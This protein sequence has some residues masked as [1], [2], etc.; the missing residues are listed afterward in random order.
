MVKINLSFL[1]KTHTTTSCLTIQLLRA[2]HPVLSSSKYI[3]SIIFFFLEKTIF[4]F[5]NISFQLYDNSVVQL[6]FLAELL[7]GNIFLKTFIRMGQKLQFSCEFQISLKT[8]MQK[9]GGSE[10]FKYTSAF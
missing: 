5:N 2:S 9:T 3:L 6:T 10:N 1:W 8:G 4:K 7:V